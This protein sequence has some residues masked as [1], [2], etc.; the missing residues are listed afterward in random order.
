[1]SV[2]LQNENMKNIFALISYLILVTGCQSLSV[3]APGPFME[4]PYT[5]GNER[6]WG[7]Q[8]GFR[9]GQFVTVTDNAGER[10]APR[11][12]NPGITNG[13]DAYGGVS[14]AFVDRLE[15]RGDI[16][17]GNNFSFSLMGK[18][19]FLGKSMK[20]SGKG[21]FAM[22]GYAF[23]TTGGISR[24]GDQANTFGAGGYN[25]KASVNMT[26]V[27]LG[28][29][30]GYHFSDPFMLFMAIARGWYHAAYKIDH[31]TSRDGTYPAANYAG[32]QYGQSD[33]V[34]LGANIVFS[35]KKASLFALAQ[36]EN[37]LWTNDKYYRGF[38]W[39][40]GVQLAF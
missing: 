16:G 32:T 7:G 38:Q 14:Y 33:V 35:E 40:A 3:S 4:T 15:V 12:D 30:A 20:E 1:M 27:G 31:E 22:A 10:P 23:S 8:A 11:L 21:N 39:S 25:W 9:S 29:S 26:G 19:Q 24:S 17:Y 36:Y 6:K 28:L 5:G 37:R 34:G 13:G 18:Y 2:I